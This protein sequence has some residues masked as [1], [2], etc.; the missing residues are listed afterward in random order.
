VLNALVAKITKGRRASAKNDEM[1]G[2]TLTFELWPG[3]PKEAEV[4]QLLATT[5]AKII[6]LWEEVAQ[7][8]QPPAQGGE[9]QV[10]FYCGQNVVT[11]E[12][13]E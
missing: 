10:H 13:S 1:G 4:R 8:E 5:R 3:H 2:T 11:E 12:D 6:P 7:Y 9:Y